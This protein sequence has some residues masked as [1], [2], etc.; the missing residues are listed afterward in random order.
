MSE[1]KKQLTEED[2]SVMIRDLRALKESAEFKTIIAGI[3]NIIDTDRE[4]IISAYEGN[5]VDHEAK[6]SFHCLKW[7]ENKVFMDFIE[8]ITREWDGVNRMKSILQDRI[9]ANRD[10]LVNR[11][12]QYGSPYSIVSYTDFDKKRFLT[13]SRRILISILDDT[14]DSLTPPKK[15]SDSDTDNDEIYQS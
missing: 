8:S 10:S 5:E 1:N 4:L 9:E 11:I 7:S 12:S 15:T 3:Q 2:I 6:Y 14:I 13:I